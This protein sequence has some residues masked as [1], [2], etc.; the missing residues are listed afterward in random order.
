MMSQM[1]IFAVTIM[2]VHIE[3]IYPQLC[4]VIRRSAVVSVCEE[5][6]LWQPM[7]CCAAMS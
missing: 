7:H 6:D 3:K 1:M 4:Q 5:A 2:I